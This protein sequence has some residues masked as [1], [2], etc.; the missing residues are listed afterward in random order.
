MLDFSELLES[1]GFLILAGGGVACELVG[2]LYSKRVMEF[3]FPIWQ[4]LIMMAGTVVAAAIFAG[5]D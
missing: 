2:W 1:P 4:L 5:R 3:S